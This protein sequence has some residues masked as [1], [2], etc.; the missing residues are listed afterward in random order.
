MDSFILGT[1]L[2]DYIVPHSVPL[3]VVFV[4]IYVVYGIGYYKMFEKA[5]ERPWKGFIPVYSLYTAF[6]T[7]WREGTFVFWVMLAMYAISLILFAMIS[8]FMADK[9]AIGTYIFL[10]VGILL[11][12]MVVAS[13]V[14]F[15]IKQANAYSK[16]SYFAVLALFFPNV[17]VLYYGFAQTAEYKGQQ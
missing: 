10:G 15:Y 6:K 3:L 7:A 5:E 13:L 2:E 4:A 9:S 12:A 8:T 1:A 11:R 17:M 16:P 14:M